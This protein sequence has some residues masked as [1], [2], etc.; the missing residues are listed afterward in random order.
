MTQYE[1]VMKGIDCCRRV[2]IHRGCPEE[3]PYLE[4][5]MI[6]CGFDALLDDIE[7]LLKKEKENE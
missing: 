2:D 1:K 6:T 5:G 3:C 7:V 4:E